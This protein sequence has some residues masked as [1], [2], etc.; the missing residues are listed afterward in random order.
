MAIGLPKITFLGFSDLYAWSSPDP[1]S[2]AVSAIGGDAA[3]AL[4]PL[5][6]SPLLVV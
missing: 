1:D 5:V 3:Q 4:Q 6:N 2:A